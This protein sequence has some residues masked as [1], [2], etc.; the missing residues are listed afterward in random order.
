MPPNP[1]SLISGGLQTLGGIGQTL[2]SGTRKKERALEQF[3]ESAP[4]Y[5]PNQSILDYYQKAYNRY[6]P[7]AY[8]S[9]AYRQGQQNINSNMAAGITA[10]QDRRSGLAGISNLVA[11]SN[12]AAL[13]NIANAERVQAQNLNQ[14]GSAAAAKT[15]EDRMAFKVNKQDPFNRKY[16]L[17]A[18]KAGAA[19]KMKNDGLQNIFGGLSN[20]ASLGFGGGNKKQ[21]DNTIWTDSTNYE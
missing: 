12:R 7:N 13:G 3:N 19:A 8:N 15:N 21:K 6:D 9:A 18:M 20:I 4:T 1:L 16:N 2:F 17:L 5:T 10:T 14:L 11:Q